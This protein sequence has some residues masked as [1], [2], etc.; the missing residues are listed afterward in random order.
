MKKIIILFI[1][2][3]SGNLLF[4]QHG[5]YVSSGNIEYEKTINMFAYI[6]QLATSYPGSIYESLSDQYQ[7]NQPQFVKVKS[8]LAF[9][10]SKTL[11]TPDKSYVGTG[12]FGNSVLTNQVNLVYTDLSANSLV[13]QKDVLSNQFLVK[14]S[15]SK[16]KWRI[17]GGSQDIAGY[18]CREAHGI[19]QD[20]IYVVAFYADKIA[21]SGGPES[22]SGLPGMILSLIIPHEHVRWD[23]T[24]VTVEAVPS[25]QIVPPKKGKPVNNKQ[26]YDVLKEAMKN[27]GPQG[28]YNLKF[29]LL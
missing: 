2:L 16:I 26:L 24:K 28:A 20:S 9:N 10:N 15:T 19:I 18:K 25:T 6:R 11:F 13:V 27:W 4:A 23:A 21:V 1:S 8:T 5:K 12:I 7:K 17:V 22:F 14:D 29:Y 3:L